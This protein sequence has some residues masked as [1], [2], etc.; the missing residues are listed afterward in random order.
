MN[1]VSPKSIITLSIRARTR[2]ITLARCLFSLFTLFVIIDMKIILSI[3]KIISIMVRVNN[4][5]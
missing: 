2:P 5:I 1:Q 3:P 4:A